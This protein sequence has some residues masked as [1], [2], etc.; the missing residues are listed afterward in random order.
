MTMLT[1]T[2]LTILLISLLSGCGQPPIRVGDGP[3]IDV[4][5]TIS[6]PA[7]TAKRLEKQ[8]KYQQAAEEYLKIAAQSTPPTRQGHQLSAIKVYFKGGMLD[9]ARTELAKLDTGQSYGLEIPLEFMRIKIDLAEQQAT[10]A[11]NRLKAIEPS[12]LPPPLQLEYKQ[13]HAQAI[14]AKGEVVQAVREWMA[15]DDSANADPTVIKEN[16]QQL[17]RS[18][19]T[20]EQSALERVPQKLGDTL[21]GWTALALLTKTSPQKQLAAGINNWQLR[22]PNHP[23]TQYIVPTLV[24]KLD[25]SPSPPKQVALLLAPVKSKFGK[26]AEAVQNGFFA[27]LEVDS[28]GNRPNVATYEVNANDVLEVYQKAV[29]GG[30]D[31]VVGP[32]LKNTLS[33][34]AESYVQLP[35][36][37]LGLNHLETPVVTGNLYQFALSPEDEAR[38][39]ATRA[40]A[41][42]HRSALILVPEGNWGERVSTA[43]QT[44]WEKQGGQVVTQ[45]P[46]GSKFKS[47]IPRILRKR[48]VKAADMAF[49]VA[50][51][52]IARQII[53]LFKARRSDLPIYST[54]HVYSGTPNPRYDR[55]SDSV[56]FVDMPWVLD[57][58]EN[59]ALMQTTLQQ[60][61]PKGM[62]KYKRLY[63]LGIDAY[64]SLPQLQQLSQPQWQGQTGRLF[65]DNSGIIHRDQLQFARFAEGKPQ[66]VE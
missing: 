24:P 3:R 28:E 61:S 43:F 44:E 52:K 58:D 4:K 38:E 20:L 12:T 46:Y 34:L 36:P 18:L 32:L 54:S 41:D 2:T 16:H 25:Q 30:A 48:S 63:A 8:G 51:P 47:S 49:V 66:L 40:W 27:A 65:V 22:F 5:P 31:F 6:D 13:L 59:G 23:A 9:E 53:P 39:V 10:S 35:V 64:Y 17:W 55:K 1:R 62:K 37:T 14:A 50:F 26:Q 15:I 11:L 29:A 19:S 21:S 57:P 60:S 42:G 7:E 45:S 33:V 56:M